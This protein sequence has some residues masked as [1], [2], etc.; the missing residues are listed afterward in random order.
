MSHCIKATN[1]SDPMYEDI[2]GEYYDQMQAQLDEHNK[3]LPKEEQL[4]LQE[5]LDE[6]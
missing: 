4:E 1:M 2:W 3:N 6:R 5:Y